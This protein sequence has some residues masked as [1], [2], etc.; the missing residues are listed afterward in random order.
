MNR[1][2]KG[3]SDANVPDQPAAPHLTIDVA[4]V[5]LLLQKSPAFFSI[6]SM[7]AR[8]VLR[9]FCQKKWVKL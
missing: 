2:S 1:E 9:L 4:G 3:P 6:I 5:T 7:A 8:T